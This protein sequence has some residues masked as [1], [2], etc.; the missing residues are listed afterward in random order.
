VTNAARSRYRT[1]PSVPVWPGRAGRELAEHSPTHSAARALRTAGIEDATLHDLRR[2]AGSLALS[3]GVPLLVV[4][5]FVGHSSP[6]VKARVYAH[7]LSDDALAEV[8][9]AFEAVYGEANGSGEAAAT[10]PQHDRQRS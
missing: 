5:R 7:L 8:P 6:L 10:T 3:K 4:S 1:G 9:A 2:T